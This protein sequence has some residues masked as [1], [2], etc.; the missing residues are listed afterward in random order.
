MLWRTFYN[1][2][3]HLEP[4]SNVRMLLAC[5]F[6]FENTQS[7]HFRKRKRTLTIQHPYILIDI[8]RPLAEVEFDAFSERK[9]AEVHVLTLKYYSFQTTFFTLFFLIHLILSRFS[10]FFTDCEYNRI[11]N[12]FHP[13]K[14]YY[15]AHQ[16][17]SKFSCSVYLQ[18]N[19][20][21]FSFFFFFFCLP[22]ALIMN[23]MYSTHSIVIRLMIIWETGQT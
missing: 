9:K 1:I 5:I 14:P 7:S 16:N 17:L 3:L 22:N 19:I 10:L 21:F 15:F 6:F 20:S 23:A 4:C 8:A 11:K 2:L 18:F 12:Q 13:L